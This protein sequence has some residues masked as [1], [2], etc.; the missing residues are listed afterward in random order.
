MTPAKR[1]EDPTNGARAWAVNGCKQAIAGGD[2]RK[3]R[4]FAKANQ[5]RQKPFLGS[6]AALGRVVEPSERDGGLQLEGPGALA[7]G[8]VNGADKR[9]FRTGAVGRTAAEQKVTAAP[10]HLRLD[11]ALASSL[12]ISE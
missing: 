1:S 3:F 11:P 8:D 9:R 10:M 7:T 5:G 4:S 2:C 6:R 12:D